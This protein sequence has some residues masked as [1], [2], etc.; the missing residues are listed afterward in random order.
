MIYSSLK[1]G[2]FSKNLKRKNHLVE[3]NAYVLQ[4]THFTL[5]YVENSDSLTLKFDAKEKDLI[6]VDCKKAYEEL[7]LQVNN[8]NIR[9]PYVSDWALVIK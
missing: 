3:S 1:K 4:D 2:R 5:I 9:M 8:Q 7:S 6:A